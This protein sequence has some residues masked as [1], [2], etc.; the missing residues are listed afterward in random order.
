MKKKNFLIYSG[1]RSDYG[2]LK[3]LIF[4]LQKEKLFN[5]KII[6]SG[7]HFSKKFGYTFNE[8]KKDKIKF[9]KIDCGFDSDDFIKIIKSLSL[10]NIRIS[11]FLV[12]EKINYL[13]LLGDR[14]DLISVAYPAVLLG[15]KICH[16]HGG[17]LSFKVVDE[18]IRHSITKLSDYHFVSNEKY[19]KRVIQMGEDKNTVFNVG[20]L[21]IDAIKK[22]SFYNKINLEQKLNIDLK[23]NFFLITYQPLSSD[24][25]ESENFF[26]N[27]LKALVYFKNYNLIFT[28]PNIDFGSNNIIA[29]LKKFNKKN[30]NVKVFKSLGQKN[31][32]SLARFASAVVGNS[33]SGIIEIPFMGVPVVNIGDRQNGREKIKQ[34]IDVKKSS[35]D[36][37]IRALKKSQKLKYQIYEKSLN[38]TL[39]GNGN[40][41]IKILRIL[42]KI[43][44]TK[45][46]RFKKFFDY[47]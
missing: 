12:K 8:A 23:K 36:L 17:E 9:S 38:N 31:Y 37:I 4:E 3:H 29:K 13:I 20:S 26:D 19:K 46:K 2:I 7:S 27:L 33:S 5:T 35:K 22:M 6:L 39:Y 15:I 45:K 41:A 14:F 16:I 44:S 28:F 47:N 10:L 11:K 24:L 18:Y 42:K 30:K 25:S 40:S 21:S 34:I 1:S 32:L 43:A